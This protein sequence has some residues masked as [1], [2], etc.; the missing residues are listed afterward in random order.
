MEARPVILANIFGRGAIETFRKEIK[1]IRTCVLALILFGAAMLAEAGIF[2]RGGGS[3][4][5][6]GC[7]T[8]CGSVAESVDNQLRGTLNE[9]A[10]VVVRKNFVAQ[11]AAPAAP[12]A[13]TTCNKV[14][15]Q[16]ASVAAV[17]TRG[18]GVQVQSQSGY[19]SGCGS[20][21]CGGGRMGIVGRLFRR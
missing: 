6:G 11:V 13:C 15:L 21:S 1:M 10:P 8:T 20:G 16:P 17:D 14:A 18:L 19:N 3:C 5:S 9:D 2:R 7:Q 12:E 4:G